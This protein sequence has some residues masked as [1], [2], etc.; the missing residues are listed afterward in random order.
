MKKLFFT[1]VVL[2]AVH[3]SLFAQ[4]NTAPQKFVFH[5]INAVGLMN[6]SRGSSFSLQSI[7]GFSY[8]QFFAGVGA[9]ID[10]YKFRTV[11]LFV[12]LR[13]KPGHKKR[14]FFLYGDLGYSV[15]WLTDKEK[16]GLISAVNAKAAIYYDAGLGYSIPVQKDAFLL[17]IGY[18][19]K[20][21][22]NRA[23]EYTCTTGSCGVADQAYRYQMERI[24]LRAAWQF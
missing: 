22:K 24:V 5:S 1:F 12:D 14:N 3:T 20:E 15:P 11:P 21:M 10:F 23:K 17:S 4:T 8:R 9:G 2:L 6:G 13:Y 18:S 16:T 7:E 19:Y